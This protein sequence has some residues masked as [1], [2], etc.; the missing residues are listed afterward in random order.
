MAEYLHTLRLFSPSL[1]R[2]LLALGLVTTV[3]FGILAVLFNLYLLRLGFDARAIGLLAAAG[4]IVW[5]AVALPAGMLSSRIGLRISFQLGI[6]VYSLGI[7]LS[8]LVEQLPA[9]WWLG[10]L[11][12]TQ[13]VLYV[14]VALI[15][16]VIPPY[17]M[18]V[19]GEQERRHAFAVLS[20]LVPATALLG[21]MLA[22]VLPTW[23]AGRLDMT[24]TQPAPYRLVL[25]V[26]PIVGWLSILP[27][28]GADPGRV[29]AHTGEYGPAG[30]TRLR[31]P[32]GL[33]AFWGLVVFL[34]AAGEGAVRTFYNVYLD[35]GL[36]IAPTAI[37]TVMGVAQILPIG[38][39][40][41][42][43]PLLARWGAGH[44]LAGGSFAMAVCL[45]IL[46]A[47]QGLWLAAGAYVGCIATF[48][49][50]GTGRDMLGQELVIPRWRTGS[51]AVAIIGMALGWATA[52]ILGGLLIAMRGFSALFL[53]ERASLAPSRFPALHFPSPRRWAPADA[54]RGGRHRAN[55]RTGAGNRARVICRTLLTAAHHVPG[56]GKRTPAF[57]GPGNTFR[58]D[59][60]T[61]ILLA[62][63]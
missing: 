51:Q 61:Q 53:S 34:A 59:Y 48:T 3:D 26:V 6:G 45:A 10:W 16:V 36:Q 63:N 9:A 28:M 20:A 33:L 32:F 60:P 40:L 58:S 24:L 56:T 49:L 54:S 1:R 52:G 18:A 41:L 31:P 27:L 19:T 17:V 21:S 4:Q 8:L 62:A 7:A 25:W 14:G 29:G 22:G 23:L 37:G 12:A 11:L 2:F 5:A 55:V 42:L 50:T 30:A 15:T 57:A 46:A 47:S 38:V 39:A 13:V 35:T 44:T 43:P